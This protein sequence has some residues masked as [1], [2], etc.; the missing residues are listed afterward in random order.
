MPSACDLVLVCLLKSPRDLEI[1]RLLGWY[2]IPLRTAPKV[3]AVDH[4]AFFQAGAFGER[5]GRIECTAP[6]RGYELTTRSELLRDQPDHPRAHE[7]YFKIQLG[8][9]ERLE[10]PVLA[11]RWR[12]VT[13]LYTT[14]EYLS[15]AASLNDLVVH[16][17][18]R[19]ELW[20]SLRERAERD[21]RYQVEFPEALDPEDLL[22]LLGFQDPGTGHPDEDEA[23]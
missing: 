6:V 18:E 8:P 12:R 14:G 3:V 5:G 20:R 10:R 19:A 16:D 21:Q 4:L 9:L 2:R 7:E 13:F 23:W 22:A 11:G 1:A 17:D 15:R